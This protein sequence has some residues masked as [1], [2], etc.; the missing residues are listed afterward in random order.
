M[1]KSLSKPKNQLLLLCQRSF[2]APLSQ[3][4][5][6]LD[7]RKSPPACA[8]QKTEQASEKTKAQKPRTCKS[9]RTLSPSCGRCQQNYPQNKP[10]AKNTP[11]KLCDSFR[12]A[13]PLFM[14]HNAPHYN[15]LPHQTPKTCPDGAQ[16]A[17]RQRLWGRSAAAI[18]CLA[19]EAEISQAARRRP[20]SLSSKI[21]SICLSR[22]I[23]PF[24]HA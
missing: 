13:A 12:E 11:P 14:C 3:P 4:Q 16:K 19:D 23:F 8:G 21:E 24:L 6:A 7:R 1:K 20:P 9:Q 2:P 22:K 10:Q 18:G 15:P 17:R 5:G